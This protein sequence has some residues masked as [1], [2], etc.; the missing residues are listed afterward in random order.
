MLC[1]MGGGGGKCTRTLSDDPACSRKHGGHV[2]G[3][4]TQH[5]PHP[6]DKQRVL[7]WLSQPMIETVTL[8]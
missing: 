2:S 6:D 8:V 4:S 5:E 1:V 7:L 3:L